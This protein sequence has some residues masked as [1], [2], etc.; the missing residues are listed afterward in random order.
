[1]RWENRVGGGRW[2][3]ERRRDFRNSKFGLFLEEALVVPPISR[4]QF[5]S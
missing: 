5:M 2:D 1:M 3:A 4:V